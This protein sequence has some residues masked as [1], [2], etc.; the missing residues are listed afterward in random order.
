MERE[1]SAGGV[2]LRPR[3]ERWWV[4]VIEPQ[5]KR[6]ARATVLALPKGNVDNGERPEETAVREVREE[7]GVE[8]GLVAKLSDIK[9]I[10][11][12]SWGDRQRVF[13]VVSFFCCGTAAGASGSSR[14]PCAAKCAK[15]CGCRWTRLRKNSA[16]AA[17]ATWWS[18]RGNT[19]RR[20]R[21]FRAR[22]FDGAGAFRVHQGALHGAVPIRS[23][24]QI[25]VMGALAALAAYVL[26]KL[27]S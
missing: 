7:T 16:T 6:K 21:N 14:R 26:V 15:P 12:R 5:G 23:K 22:D 4:A 3:Q 17:S 11:V 1:Y 25:L 2:V 18:W 10:Y 9:Y 24:S 8:A 20:I 13:K 19:L 27:I